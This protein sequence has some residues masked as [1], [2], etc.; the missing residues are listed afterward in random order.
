[1]QKIS[2]WWSGFDV[3]RPASRELM[4]R[5]SNPKLH[6]NFMMASGP[7]ILTFANMPAPTGGEC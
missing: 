4:R 7:S 1:M 2:H 5:T 3:R 6:H